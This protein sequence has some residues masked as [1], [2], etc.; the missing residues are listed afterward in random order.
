ML[1]S[2]PLFHGKVLFQTFLL[3]LLSLKYLRLHSKEKNVS[4]K[5]D[6]SQMEILLIKKSALKIWGFVFLLHPSC[7]EYFAISLNILH[8]AVNLTCIRCF[9][10][11]YN[12][13]LAISA[14]LVI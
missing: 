14:I 12:L 4:A 3:G 2:R 7:K 1:E 11:L 13:Q 6:A 5:A 9:L 10:K 8:S